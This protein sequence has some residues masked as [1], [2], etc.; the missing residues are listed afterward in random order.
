MAEGLESSFLVPLFDGIDKPFV[1]FEDA[2]QMTWIAPRPHLH[3]PDEPS[4]LVQELRYELEPGS[5][6]DCDVHLFVAVDE[7][8]LFACLGKT[9]LASK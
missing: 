5:L 4:Q 8:V 7:V 1:L 2:E 6:G 3:Q 9:A